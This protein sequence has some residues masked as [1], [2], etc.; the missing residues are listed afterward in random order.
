MGNKKTRQ[1][2]FS[3]AEV[4]TSPTMDIRAYLGLGTAGPEQQPLPSP[5][6]LRL[7]SHIGC[8]LPWF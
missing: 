4:P 8:Q 7:Q 3:W 5:L 1:V 2:F 6:G